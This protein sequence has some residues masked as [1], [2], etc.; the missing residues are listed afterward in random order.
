MPSPNKGEKKKAFIS[1]CM[2]SKEANKTFPDQEQRSAFCY[3]QWSRKDNMLVNL[4]SL[5]INVESREEVHNGKVHLVFPVVAL[6]E[7]VHNDVFY[8]SKEIAKSALAWNGIPVP[9]YHPKDEDGVAISANDP[10]IIDD[11]VIG[12]FYNVSF[13]VDSNKLKG[14]VWIDV[15]KADVVD[16]SVLEILKNGENMEI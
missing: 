3:S 15:D 6:V 2:G 14:E 5:K 8:P 1:R 11:V 10:T 16:A 7:G 9:V 13:D 12:R 4:K